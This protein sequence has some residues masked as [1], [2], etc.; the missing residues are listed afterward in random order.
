MNTPINAELA[1]LPP[2]ITFF[3]SNAH[4]GDS[5]PL[6]IGI[7]VNGK[8]YAFHIKPQQ[9]W[10][11]DH[12]DPQIYQGTPLSFFSEHGQNPNGIKTVIEQLTQVQ[13]VVFVLN[14]AHDKYSLEQLGCAN[15]IVEDIDEI[16]TFHTLFERVELISKTIK[17]SNLNR[18][19]VEDVI[20]TLAH[21][22]VENL[23]YQN[24]DLLRYALFRYAA[25]H[26]K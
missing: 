26:L 5:F 7:F 10:K 15:L 18:Y 3:T 11:I 9:H 25:N 2:I 19:S 21:I 12:Y 4:A 6:S 23:Q 16:D 20:Q 17:D 22:T 24:L 1:K 13:K 8:S 14:Y